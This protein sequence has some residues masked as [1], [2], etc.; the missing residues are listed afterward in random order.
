MLFVGS[1]NSKNYS[2]FRHEVSGSPCVPDEI[3]HLQRG[4]CRF[5]LVVVSGEALE[6]TEDNLEVPWYLHPHLPRPV[7]LKEIRAGKAISYQFLRFFACQS[8][9][10]S[11]NLKGP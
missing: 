1:G 5:G 11:A 4:D 6:V 2:D 8:P 3:V 7:K 10:N 9:R